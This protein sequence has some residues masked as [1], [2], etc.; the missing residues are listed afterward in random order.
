[1]SSTNSRI[2]LGDNRRILRALCFEAWDFPER[3]LS[4]TKNVMAGYTHLHALATPEW[5]KGFLNARTG[6]VLVPRTENA[7]H[8]IEAM[9]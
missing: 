5:A 1:M 2:S 9:V 3:D 6:L 7:S 8:T 4:V